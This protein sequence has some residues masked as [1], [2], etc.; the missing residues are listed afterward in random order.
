MPSPRRPSRIERADQGLVHDFAEVN[1]E[2]YE[3]KPW[4]YFEQRLL[5]LAVMFDDPDRFRRIYEQPVR[6][7]PLELN[8]TVNADPDDDAK[9]DDL[10]FAGAEAQVLLHHAAE[11]LLRLVHCHAPEEGAPAQCPALKLARV[12]SPGPFKQWVRT[13]VIEGAPDERHKL[14]VTVFGQP[15]QPSR[16]EAIGS[17]LD[18]FG[19]LFLDANPYNAAKHGLAVRGGHSRLSVDIADKQ[20]L[21]KQGLTMSWLGVSDDDQGVPRWGLTTRWF[22]PEAA[23]GAIFVATRLIQALWIVARERYL[24]DM[25]EVTFTPPL[26]RDVL[27][28]CDVPWINLVEQDRE[29]RY[30]GK[31]RILRMRFWQSGGTTRSGAPESDVTTCEQGG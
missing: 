31:D 9:Q 26:V 12:T 14:C 30:Q 10:R 8:L 16:L 13:T 4:Q 3:A 21:E 19:K 17:W 15:A 11:T 27:A 25:A 24:D 7:G 2:F 20:L 28:A 1:E 22:A 6:I 23:I 18:L 5:T 29:L